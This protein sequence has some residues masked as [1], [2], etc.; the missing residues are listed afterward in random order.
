MSTYF[1]NAAYK[2]P[3]GFTQLY[4]DETKHSQWRFHTVSKTLET[5]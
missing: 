3:I 1:L 5:S 2:Q 4:E